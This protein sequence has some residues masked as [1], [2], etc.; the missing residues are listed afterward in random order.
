MVQAKAKRELPAHLKTA[1]SSISW[2]FRSDIAAHAPELVWNRYAGRPA[3]LR[4]TNP[5]ADTKTMISQR[6]L[7]CRENRML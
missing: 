3:P 4:N 7:T 2:N 5:I 1:R 6:C